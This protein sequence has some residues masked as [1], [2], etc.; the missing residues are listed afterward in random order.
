MPERVRRFAIE[1]ESNL[2]RRHDETYRWALSNH[3]QPKT[4]GLPTENL[5]QDEARCIAGVC[6]LKCRL[7]RKVWFG[8]GERGRRCGISS[9]AEERL[10]ARHGRV[11]RSNDSRE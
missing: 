2:A 10:A 4:Y 11:R 8:K 9:V 7:R 5:I 6:L 3:T 1:S